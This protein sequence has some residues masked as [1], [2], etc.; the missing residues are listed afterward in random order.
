MASG[1]P[2]AATAYHGPIMIRASAQERTRTMRLSDV[3]V[4]TFPASP[5]TLRW[6]N[7]PSATTEWSNASAYWAEFRVLAMRLRFVPN[8]VNFANTGAL[9]SF[10]APVNW[11][12]QRDSGAPVP[13]SMTASFTFDASWPS[14]I[15]QRRTIGVRAGTSTEM[16]FQN[17][18]STSATWCVGVSQDSLTP[19]ISYG[20]VYIEQLV[21]FRSKD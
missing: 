12:I 20:L 8:F 18:R 6:T 10:Y 5:G 17:V 4:V 7:D 11:F 1:P 14:N 2:A 3:F 19:L 15:Q 16:A 21:Q 13:S 9:A